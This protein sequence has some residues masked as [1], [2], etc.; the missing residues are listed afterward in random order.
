MLFNSQQK[1]MIETGIL[2]AVLGVIVLLIFFPLA[3]SVTFPNHDSGVFLY[4]GSQI[5]KGKL[6]YIDFWDHKGPLIYYLNAVGLWITHGSQWGVWFL[7]FGFL[8]F[9]V[10]FCF[11]TVSQISNKKAAFLSNLYWLAG[12][13]LLIPG[14]LT[15]EY[16]LLFQFLSIWFFWQ[17]IRT[18]K[19]SFLVLIGLTTV[20]GFLL[21]PNLI[22]EVLAIII[23]ITILS[24]WERKFKKGI[25]DLLFIGLGITVILGIVIFYFW[26][27]GVLNEAVFTIFSYNFSYSSSTL[28]QRFNAFV[29]GLT[30]IKWL[31]PIL[32]LSPLYVYYEFKKN[33]LSKNLQLFLIFLVLDGIINILFSSISGRSYIHYYITWLPFIS[34]LGGYATFQF[35]EKFIRLFK[36]SPYQS[37]IIFS[38]GLVLLGFVLFSNKLLENIPLIEKTISNYQDLDLRITRYI[39]QNT[40]P[41]DY[42]L[43]WGYENFINFRSR[44]DSPSRFAH[45][46]PIYGKSEI[47]Q[48]WSEEFFADLSKKQPAFIVTPPTEPERPMTAIPPL[49]KETQKLWISKNA[50]YLSKGLEDSLDFINS[51]YLLYTEIDGWKV[52]KLNSITDAPG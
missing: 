7:E 31:L 26:I 4:S 34:I 13:S 5:L 29:F 35:F 38:A 42:V 27:T 2:L 8:V 21:R 19:K 40:N 20:S 50:G 6:P 51:H 47:A 37:Q 45:Q 1:S 24:L 17:W 46:F 14:N 12:L 43:A 48:K 32:I 44:R 25:I 18:G 52:Y 22:G 10:L 49:D 33:R 41:D 9:S 15:E 11:L 36:F 23:I 3:P 28:A 30:A 39:R 16:N